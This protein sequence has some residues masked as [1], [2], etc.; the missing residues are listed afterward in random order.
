MFQQEKP[1]REFFKG[2]LKSCVNGQLRLRMLQ[3]VSHA[4][5]MNQNKLSGDHWSWAT[6]S[7]T[8]ASRSWFCACHLN[9]SLKMCLPKR[10]IICIFGNQT[11]VCISLDWVQGCCFNQIYWQILSGWGIRYHI[12]SSIQQMN[13]FVVILLFGDKYKD[14]KFIEIILQETL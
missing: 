3:R 4:S 11:H 2:F 6:H 1:F 5:C 13:S 7:C 9:S 12:K 10:D 14:V 8:Q